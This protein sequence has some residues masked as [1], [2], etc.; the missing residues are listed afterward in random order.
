MFRTLTILFIS[1]FLSGCILEEEHRD[2]SELNGMWKSDNE[3][4]YEQYLEISNGQINV[5][6]IVDSLDCSRTIRTYDIA[7]MDSDIFTYEGNGRV[8][9][10]EDKYLQLKE[11]FPK[12]CESNSSNE[13]T[14][15]ITLNQLPEILENYY[16]NSDAVHLEFKIAFDTDNNGSISVGDLIFA[17]KT[18]FGGLNP[19]TWHSLPSNVYAV[20]NASEDTYGWGSVAS[21]QSSFDGDQIT[22]VAKSENFIGIG[23]INNGTQI[24]VSSSF[25]TDDHK[26]LDRYP[27]VDDFEGFYLFTS[28]VDTS[29]LEDSTNDVILT[30]NDSTTPALNL[31]PIFDIRSIEIE[32]SE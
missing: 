20:S 5:L 14:V 2:I 29:F 28:G 10:G 19:P 18:P 21:L 22:L 27:N 26:Q 16:P 25:Y 15:K 31:I 12:P 9:S 1:L 23:D 17:L 24:E 6:Y 7:T 3:N 11:A 8:Y 4:V 30:D 32:I 13:V